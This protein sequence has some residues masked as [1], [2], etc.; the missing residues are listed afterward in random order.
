[1]VC[2]KLHKFFNIQYNKI[3]LSSW[4][5]NLLKFRMW[6]AK[7]AVDLQRDHYSV[8]DSF[9]HLRHTRTAVHMNITPNVHWCKKA[10]F[11]PLE[12]TKI[13]KKFHSMEFPQPK[14]SNC[15]HPLTFV[16]KDSAQTLE[17]VLIEDLLIQL[18]RL[19]QG[20]P[21]FS[22]AATYM[23]KQSG[24]AFSNSCTGRML[25]LTLTGF[26]NCLFKMLCTA[27]LITLVD[28]LS[29]LEEDNGIY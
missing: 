23:Q 9:R 8:K 29:Y 27:P 5:W 16:K 28:E 11:F 22:R 17:E 7:E 4:P 25:Q 10:V 6:K 3:S 20:Y 12:E 2:W 15:A 21:H 1:M 14:N 26:M 18:Q 13:Q 24:T 19:L